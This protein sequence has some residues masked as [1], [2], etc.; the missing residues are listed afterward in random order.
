MT[1]IVKRLAA[2]GEI[3]AHFVFMVIE[4]LCGDLEWNNGSL[5]YA[6]KVE[7]LLYHLIKFKKTE[8]PYCPSMGRDPRCIFYRAKLF[9]K[10]RTINHSRPARSPVVVKLKRGLPGPFLI[11]IAPSGC[12]GC[13]H[14]TVRH[15]CLDFV[16]WYRC[17]NSCL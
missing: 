13:L 11:S 17:D 4:G 2:D 14:P 12:I 10:K 1:H 6:G 5:Y 3:S 15:R 7:A 8:R 9:S 16:G